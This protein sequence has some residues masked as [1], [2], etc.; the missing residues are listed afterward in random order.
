MDDIV[1][2]TFA[3]SNWCLNSGIRHV[4]ASSHQPLALN[5]HIGN[6]SS[7]GL[8]GINT[9][10]SILQ[11]Y[12]ASEGNHWFEELVMQYSKILITLR[13]SIQNILILLRPYLRWIAMI[14]SSLSQVT[15]MP[16]WQYCPGRTKEAS[17]LVSWIQMPIIDCWIWWNQKILSQLRLL[18]GDLYLWLATPAQYAGGS[19]KEQCRYVRFR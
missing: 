3:L 10:V 17:C 18:C 19:W 9:G 4:S 2:L 5:S 1:L 14:C 12:S 7:W 15:I 8:D 11:P 16:A 13:A 6:G